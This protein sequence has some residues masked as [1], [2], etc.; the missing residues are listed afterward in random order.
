LDALVMAG[1]KGSRLKM[2]E[3][4]L[5]KLF[6]RPLIDYV[7]GA[8][9][10]SSADRVF[11]AVTE[12]VP[13]T[14]E[15]AME[16]ELEVVET[17]GKGF[18]A[19]MVE[20]VEKSG[21]TEPILIIMADLPLIN[22]D[23]IDEIMETYEERPE[24]ALSTYTPLDLHRRLGRRPDSLFNYRGQL[25]VPSGINI[26]DGADIKEEQEDYHLIMERIELA[27]NVN[28]VDDLKLCESIIQGDL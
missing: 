26:L 5:V 27:V 21:V 3:K 7:V 19:D 28:V 11:V 23:L 2:G 1:G 8:L 6:G 12:N 15:W 20:A 13:M 18:V 9:L 17:S 10:D 14:E 25:I 22:P 24:P 4:P 16:R